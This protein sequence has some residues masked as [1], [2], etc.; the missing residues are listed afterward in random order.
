MNIVI[1]E[2]VNNIALNIEEV[3]STVTIEIS[4]M[5][6]PGADGKSA[7]QSAIDGGFV[8]TEFE[9]NE[10]LADVGNKVDK[11]DGYSL[12]KNDLTDEL[13]LAYDSHL[14]DI[15]NPHN[16]TKS[17]IGLNNVDNT[18]DANKPIS[19][20]TQTALNLKE[21]PIN[22]GASFG[23]APLDINSKVPLEN[24]NDALLGNVHYQGLWDATTNIPNLD[25]V[26]GKGH[27]YICT[28]TTEAT[29]YGIVFNTG[30]WIISDGTNWGK[31]D[32]TDAVSSV[33]GRVGNITAQSGDYNTG[34]VTETTDKNYQTDAQ[35]LHND[36]TSSIQTQLN[37]KA[38]DNAV[39]HLAGTETITGQKTLSPTVTASGAIAKGTNSTPSLIATA[40]ND[41]LIG[42]DIAP[43]FNSGGFTGVQNVALRLNN[44]FLLTGPAISTNT[45]FRN[46]FIDN[47][48]SIDFGI[49][50]NNSNFYL[51]TGSTNKFYLFNSTGNFTLQNGGTF[52]D[53]GARLEVN[54]STL[55]NGNI[56]KAQPVP[57]A[58]NATTTLTIANLLTNIITSTNTIAISLT[59][60]TGTLTDAGILGG[61]LPVNNGFDWNL[62]NTGT[63]S[64][65]VTIV[66]ATGHTIV[67]SAIVGIG[68]SAGFRT[69]KTA[70]NTYVTYR[71]N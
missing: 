65:I 50:T 68:A 11:V 25:V 49:R 38:L 59:L 28:N 29:R 18:S 17:Q 64:G 22:K 32:N 46:D 48:S 70:T 2:I 10:F 5:Q 20:A 21:D 45:Y 47:Y 31:V 8:G 6:V 12:T 66:A 67:G 53:K 63:V 30:D 52:T 15:S 37:A 19:T 60:P 1:E 42:L 62:I 41:V 55:Q 54:G 26:E 23:Y 4:E 43:I 58:A 3:V 51:R 34:Q 24:I 35:K 44:L 56:Y 14:I 69:V 36:A 27:Y 40:N 33:F 13:K 71:I 9:F 39:V 61:L 57:T 7:Y 16:V